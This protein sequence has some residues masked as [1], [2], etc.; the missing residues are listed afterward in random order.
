MEM[1]A[2]VME[3]AKALAKAQ[4]ELKSAKKNKVNPHFRS[5]YADLESTLEAC[6]E[7]LSRNGLSIVQMPFDTDG[8]IGVET[9]LLHESGEWIKGNLAVK[10]TQETNPQNAGSIL[11]YLR[12][13]SLQAAVGIATEDDDAD[14]VS[15]KSSFI[16]E[17]RPGTPLDKDILAGFE[18]A[19]T[20]EEVKKV[21]A[22]VPAN[23]R[24]AYTAAKNAAKDRVA[25][26]RAA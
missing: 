1:S 12:R 25:K 3:L 22:G 4:G 10:M 2:S 6:R 23:Q 11:S 20:E 24:P 15:D 16:A 21:W 8:R 26:R 19:A 14:A 7:P 13:Y 18:A 17:D 5:Q 9:V